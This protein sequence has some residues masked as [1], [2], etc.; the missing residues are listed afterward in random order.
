MENTFG[1]CS[2]KETRHQMIPNSSDLNNLKNINL[3]KAVF[4]VYN[5]R[6]KT[7]NPIIPL[8]WFNLFT[9]IN[10]LSEEEEEI[11]KKT[12]ISFQKIDS[13]NDN[14]YIDYIFYIICFE[15]II[16]TRFIKIYIYEK[17]DDIRNGLSK[18]QRKNELIWTH[19]DN[20]IIFSKLKSMYKLLSM[21]QIHN[22]LE[23]QYSSIEMEITYI[24]EEKRIAEEKRITE[25]KRI[26]KK[27]RRAEVEKNVE[28]ELENRKRI[29]EEEAET[30][31]EKLLE[32]ED[33]KKEEANKKRER[34]R[35]KKQRKKFEIKIQ[36]FK[37]KY[38]SIKIQKRWRE[39]L[40]KD[41]E[42]YSNNPPIFNIRYGRRIIRHMVK[43][44]ENKKPFDITSWDHEKIP[45]MNKEFNNP[46]NTNI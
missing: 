27:K 45:H 22:M 19:P 42:L 21:D 36:K 38:A 18:E 31:A 8:C 11:L 6:D 44:L 16:D 28:K 15:P 2:I 39:I 24:N 46:F 14:T 32:A 40:K 1:I 33:K 43:A 29:A 20:T 30:K 12:G 9:P 13:K 3:I 41:N 34:N 17:I 35:K 37:K 25:E 4:E 10:R 23:N 7:E 26:A 5:T